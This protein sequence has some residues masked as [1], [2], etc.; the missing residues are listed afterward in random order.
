MSPE[1]QAILRSLSSAQRLAALRQLH[2]SAR[3]IKAAAVRSLHPDW[4]ETQV[5]ETVREAFLYGRT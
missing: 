1:E 4:T 3:R 5:Q 2:R